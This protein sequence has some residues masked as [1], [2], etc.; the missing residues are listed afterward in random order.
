[1]ATELKTAKIDETVLNNIWSRASA[2]AARAP[3]AD[4]AQLRIIVGELGAEI[5]ALAYHLKTGKR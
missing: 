3:N 4:L 1:M 5:A 2:T